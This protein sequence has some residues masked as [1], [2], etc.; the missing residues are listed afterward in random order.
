MSHTHNMKILKYV[1]K[2]HQSQ[3]KITSTW[4]C[5]VEHMSFESGLKET[6]TVRALD[7]WTSVFQ[8]SAAEGSAPNEHQQEER[9]TVINTGACGQG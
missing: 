5:S 3:C 6:E 8:R 4:I 2:Q 1:P 9:I 7:F